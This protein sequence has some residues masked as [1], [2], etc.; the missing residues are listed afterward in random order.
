MG[1][2][3]ESDVWDALEATAIQRAAGFVVPANASR[4][5]ILNH[6]DYLMRFLNEVDADI[7]V[8]ELREALE[9]YP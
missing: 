7:S 5:S 2:A 3:T 4:R 9:D 8:A 6:R 1:A